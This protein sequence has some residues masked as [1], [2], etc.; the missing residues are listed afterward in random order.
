[1]IRLG[2]ESFMLVSFIRG[3]GEGRWTAINVLGM[4]HH[5]FVAS[6]SPAGHS[7]ARSGATIVATV[8]PPS[9]PTVTGVLPATGPAAGG[10]SVTVTGTGFTGAT[11]VSFGSVP[12]TGVAVASDTQLTVTSPA[13]T[14]GAVVDV[15]VTTP[16]GA[17]TTWPRDQF[18]Y[19]L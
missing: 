3:E 4:I 12:G 19:G 17:S 15:T 10:T 5:G 18:H 7:L 8:T 1:M 11:G 6:Q 16:S 2:I 14:S 13:G 9:V